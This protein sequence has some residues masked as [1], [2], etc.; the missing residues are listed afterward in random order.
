MT[1]EALGEIARQIGTTSGPLGTLG[2]FL[3]WKMHT[4]EQKLDRGERRTSRLFGALHQLGRLI[5]VAILTD[6]DDDDDLPPLN[7]KAIP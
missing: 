4:I 2:L 6:D 1:D 3:L 7:A 5:G